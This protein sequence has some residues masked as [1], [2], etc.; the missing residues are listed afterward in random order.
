VLETW[1]IMG[2]D[3]IPPSAELTAVREA[4]SAFMA[5]R[6]HWPAERRAQL[7]AELGALLVEVVRVAEKLG[8]DA[9][10]VARKA[11]V[12]LRERE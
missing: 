9:V 4:L 12:A 5:E 1:A 10:S 3:E 2:K 8:L 11:L 6:K 7:E